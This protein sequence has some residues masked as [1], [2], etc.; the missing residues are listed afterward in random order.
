MNFADFSRANKARSESPEG[1]NHKLES[2]S[3]SH[4]FTAAMGE[5]GEAANVAKKLN[6]VRDGI[7]GN[8]KSEEELRL[9]LADELADTYIY[10]DLLAQSQGIDLAGAVRRKFNEK[11]EE[12]GYPER[13]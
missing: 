3:L 1:F 11:S 6:R 13:I 10:L 5:L 2:W 12:I 8:K 9:D 7:P 4:W